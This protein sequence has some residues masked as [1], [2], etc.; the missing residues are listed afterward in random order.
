MDNIDDGIGLRSP[1]LLRLLWIKLMLTRGKKPRLRVRVGP[2]T[3]VT[4]IISEVTRQKHMWYEW[5]LDVWP[6][7]EHVVRPSLWDEPP[8]GY[9]LSVTTRNKAARLDALLG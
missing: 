3:K 8:P 4:L 9:V 5:A 6:E 2:N 7:P 1:S